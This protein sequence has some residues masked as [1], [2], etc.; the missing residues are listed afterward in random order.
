MACPVSVQEQLRG[1]QRSSLPFGRRPGADSRVQLTGGR[2]GHIGGRVGVL[3]PRVPTA[4]G[5]A[6]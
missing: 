5:M 6:L 4:S 3:S 2:M 1:C